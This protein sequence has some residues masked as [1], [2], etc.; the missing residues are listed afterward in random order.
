MTE[1]LDDGMRHMVETHMNA[2]ESKIKYAPKKDSMLK[3]AMFVNGA[4]S[5]HS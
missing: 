3:V 4:H 2:M 1:A 5:V